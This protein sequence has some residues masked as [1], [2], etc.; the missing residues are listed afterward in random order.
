MLSGVL[1]VLSSAP[2]DQWYLSYVAYVPLFLVVRGES[3]VRQGLLFALAC[4]AI[5][6]N[7]WH[8]T[9]IYS[10]YFFLFI[11]A[12][13]CMAFFFWGY[14]SSYYRNS[15]THPLVALFAPAVIW[16]GIERLLS[17]EWVGIPCNIGISQYSQPILIQ[18]A[19]LFGIYTTS[20]LIVLVNTFLAMLVEDWK[21][22]RAGETPHWF[23][24]GVA[25]ALIGLNAW[26]GVSRIAAAPENPDPLRV[27]VVQPVISTDMYLNGWRNPDTRKFIR[28]TL[29]TLT[30]EAAATD[31]DILAWPEG[32]NGYF[33]MRISELR[34]ALYKTAIR[35]DT[36]LLISSNDLDGEGR[37]Y[38]VVFSISREGR[39]LGRYNKVNL[40]PGAED[41]YTAGKGFHPIPGSF[42]KIGPAICYES[43][44]P[45]PLR[46]VTQQGA[47]LLFVS[48]SDAAFKKTALSINHTR[49]AIFRAI[50]NNRWVIH[51]S[52]TGSSVIVSPQGHVIASKGFYERG[53]IS[54]NVGMI[55]KPSVFVRFGYHVP[56]LFS[57]VF[58]LLLVMHL[59]QGA[60]GLACKK[61][62]K[63]HSMLMVQEELEQRVK[64]WGL[65]IVRRYL[66]ATFLYSIFLA[67]I[68]AGSIMLAYS[69]TVSNRPAYY[70]L[71]E[72]FDPLDTLE[73]DRVT[74][75]FLQA[76]SNSCG[77]AVMAYVFSFFGK[78]MLE[79]RVMQQVTM[80]DEGTSLL[81][82]KKV[83]IKNKFNATGV[84]ENYRALMAEPLPVIAYINDDHYVVVNKITSSS[85]YLFDPAI[86][87]VQIDRA[88][89]ERVWNGYL[90]LIRMQPIKDSI[91]QL[92]NG[93]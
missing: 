57:A 61:T 85:V 44:F 67:V 36:D 33:N 82:L 4:T 48:T 66:P 74:Q 50:E 40:I 77:P 9:I 7:W 92:S 13:L 38:N 42:G 14:L 54:G 56:Q 70:A 3:P 72:F 29:A 15:K 28:D 76:K 55:Q 18:S 88:V 27:A 87:H 8:S 65:V 53:V 78:E 58:L 5:A 45:S 52:N 75:K 84:A 46:K 24:H 49:T 51:A 41:S 22:R 80:T 17:S 81:E 21:D 86:G 20:F 37:K 34:D 71:K 63:D 68:I 6:S 10:T 69:R 39:L 32:G 90:L 73:P 64:G 60:R 83:A 47:E 2:Y 26:Y 25:I 79:D 43:N 16:V 59:Y 89:F 1:M 93:A 91:P 35:Y 11:V 12:M 19:S 31:P 23:A 62:R 30:E